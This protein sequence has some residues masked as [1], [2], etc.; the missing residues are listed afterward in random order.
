MQTFIRFG[1]LAVAITTLAALSACTGIEMGG[2]LWIS[3]V[4]ERQESQKTHNI[5][6]KC[7]LWQDCGQ[8][9]DNVK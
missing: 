3:R 5:P 7:Y 1:Y 2:K 4:D 8:P 9:V 6:L